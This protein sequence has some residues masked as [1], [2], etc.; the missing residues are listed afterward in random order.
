MSALSKYVN[1]D[2]AFQGRF[3]GSTEEVRPPV[4]ATP[5]AAAAAGVATAK[6][7]GA[8]VGAGAVTGAAYVAYRVVA[9]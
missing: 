8:L 3:S 4:M 2:P 6:L 9:K 7:A 5:A 1:S